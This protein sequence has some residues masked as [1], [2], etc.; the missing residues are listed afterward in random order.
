[1]LWHDGY[2]TRSNFY[3]IFSPSSNEKQESSASLM[4]TMIWRVYVISVRFMNEMQGEKVSHIRA[5]NQ[6]QFESEQQPIKYTY[7]LFA[8]RTVDFFRELSVLHFP[9]SVICSVPQ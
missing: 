2:Y 8:P 1:M 3:E 7:I 9:E 5:T 4:A 6:S